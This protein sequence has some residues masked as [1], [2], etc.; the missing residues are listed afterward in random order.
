MGDSDVASSLY[1]NAAEIWRARVGVIYGFSGANQ[2]FQGSSEM[3]KYDLTDPSHTYTYNYK[4]LQ[5]A[6]K[7]ASLSAGVD[8][9]WGTGLSLLVPYAALKF[10]DWTTDPKNGGTGS[11]QSNDFGDSEIRVRQNVLQP[12][13]IKPFEGTWQLPRI[14]ATLGAVIPNHGAYSSDA[15]KEL[16]ISRGAYWM[17]EELEAHF[18]LPANFGISLNGGAR[19][20]LTYAT[21]GEPNPNGIGWGNE[22]RGAL[23]G[24]YMLDMP[25]LEGVANYFVPKRLML[26]V[27]AEYLYR[28]TST[29]VENVDAGRIDFASSGGKTV[30]VTPTLMI[31]YNDAWSVTAS[32][33]VPVYRF[34][35]GEQPVQYTSW[36]FGLNWSWSSSPKAP[37]LPKGPSRGDAP[38][39]TEIAQLLVPGKYTIVDYWATWC[40][41]CGRLGVKLEHELPAKPGVALAR[42]DATA[43]EAEEWAKFLPGAPGIPVLDLYD[44]QGKLIVRLQGDD[45]FGYEAHLPADASQA[46]AP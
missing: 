11:T 4:E 22:Y 27:N 7:M 23:S 32:A 29:V 42:M 38:T 28:A 5:M 45:C 40:E 16:S 41:P 9:P 14:F 18:E 46:T 17:I 1:T 25:T 36:F 19:Q 6:M 39:T 43:W 3:P 33:R 20:A 34:V 31:G 30:S 8:A 44:R 10:D 37:E 35:N 26:L 13:H 12:F 15:I 2:L 21:N 24:R